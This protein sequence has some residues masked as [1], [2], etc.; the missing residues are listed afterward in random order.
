L[1][2]GYLHAAAIGHLALEAD[3]PYIKSKSSRTITIWITT[4]KIANIELLRVISEKMIIVQNLFLRSLLLPLVKA[5]RN[6]PFDGNGIVNDITSN[7]QDSAEISFPLMRNNS[8]HLPDL[9]TS[10]N[11]SPNQK[12]ICLCVRDELHSYNNV[13]SESANSTSYRNSNIEDYEKAIQYFINSGFNVIRMGRLAKICD[14]RMS[15]FYDYANSN[16]RSDL[17]DLVIFANCEFA[18][19]TLT[20]IDELASLYRKPVYIVNYLP[21]GFFRLSTKR[22]LVLPKGLRDRKSRKILS[23]EQIKQRGLWTANSTNRYVRENVDI[24]NCDAETLVRFAEQVLLHFR[25][26]EKRKD[27]QVSQEVQELFASASDI[28]LELKNKIPLISELWLNYGNGNSS[29]QHDPNKN[30][31]D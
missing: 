8:K 5:T 3:I 15:G 4:E 18:F 17:N 21:V 26:S 13:S 30:K 28:P 6:T 11:F 12:Y 16:L 27:S 31:K 23:I 24:E 7:I 1:K 19:S 9:L 25:G 20:G 22:P 14:F 10:M 2:F 29:S